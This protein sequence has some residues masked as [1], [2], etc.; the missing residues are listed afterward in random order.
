MEIKLGGQ[1]SGDIKLSDKIQSIK[2][3]PK[4]VADD[5]VS[6]G[7]AEERRKINKLI[8]NKCNYYF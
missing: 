2:K 8:F 5:N 3:D 6:L 1:V 4:T 7:V